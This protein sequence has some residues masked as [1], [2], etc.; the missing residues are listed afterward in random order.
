MTRIGIYGSLGRMGIAIT[1][2]AP[3]LNAQVTGGADLG[4]DPAPL[5]RAVDVLVDFSAPRARH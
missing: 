1:E 4:D 2:V 3:E 5:A